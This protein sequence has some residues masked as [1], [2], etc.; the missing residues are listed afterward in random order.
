M[1]I[2]LKRNAVENS[3]TIDGAKFDVPNDKVK[4]DGLREFVVDHYCMIH[5]YAPRY[6]TEG[7]TDE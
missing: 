7:S 6:G 1:S 5:G 4:Q 3:I 2:V